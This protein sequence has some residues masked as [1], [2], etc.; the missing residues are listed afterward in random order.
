GRADYAAL[1]SEPKSALE[2]L[3]KRSG[4]QPPELEAAATLER[5]KKRLSELKS[6][7]FFDA[8]GRKDAEAALRRLETALTPRKKEARRG[9]AAHAELLGR[10][11]V[12]RRGIQVDR[13]ASAWLV[14]RF[15]DRDARFR[16]VDPKE[17]EESPGEIRF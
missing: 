3:R 10:T 13:I 17:T 1:G 9:R 7:D 2:A 5:L 12:T 11:W 16:F 6:I 14:R 4:V 8:P 15:V